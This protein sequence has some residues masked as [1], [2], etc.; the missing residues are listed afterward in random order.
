MTDQPSDHVPG[1]GAPAGSPYATPPGTP[2]SSPLPQ[3]PAPAPAAAPASPAPA[4]EPF[5]AP[6]GPGYQR[7]APAPAEPDPYGATP[8]PQDPYPPSPDAYPGSPAPQDPYAAPSQN[9]YAPA[10]TAGPGLPASP[11]SLAA[12]EARFGPVATF[13]ERATSWLIDLGVTLSG[14]LLV[15]LG[16]VVLWFGS[17]GSVTLDNGAIAQTPSDPVLSAIGWVFVIGG[18]L[19]MLGLWLWNRV[20]TMGRTGQS[21]GKRSQGLLLI[22]A[23]TGQPIGAGSAFLRDLVHGLANQ[24]FYL[25]FLW[26]L[27]D[28]DRQ[29]LGDKAVHS[30]VVRVPKGGGHGATMF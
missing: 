3:S 2:Y 6:P 24:V 8:A 17:S 23:R 12:V 15:I 25:S 18:Y 7:A 5:G 9:P 11:E 1:S 26:M 16:V 14:L 10:P 29:T 21:V 22:D 13:G 27:W 30:T 4:A 19:A 20:F 28:P